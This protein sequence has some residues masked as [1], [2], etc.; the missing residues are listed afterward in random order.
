MHFRKF[1]P[2]KLQDCGIRRRDFF[3]SLNEEIDAYFTSMRDRTLSEAAKGRGENTILRFFWY[4]FKK[5]LTFFALMLLVSSCCFNPCKEECAP[6]VWR[7]S[8][9]CVLDYTPECP[10]DPSN[11][12][13]KCTNCKNRK[14]EEETFAERAV[15]PEYEPLIDEYYV[16]IGDVLEISVF[17]DED[18]LV[19]NVI[20]AP[21]GKIYY[22]NL[23]GFYAEGMTLDEIGEVVALGLSDLFLSP[24]V[25]VIPRIMSN[26]TF[27][28][29]GRVRH[30]GLFTLERTITLRQAVGIAGGILD[31]P[32]FVSGTTSQG[33][34]YISQ[35][36]N[37][38]QKV[39]SLKN[40]FI[41][42]GDKKLSIDFDNLIN[43]PDNTQDIVVKAGD[44]I[45]IAA[46]ESREVFVLG[47]AFAPSAV[48]YR[49]ELTLM[50]AL[51]AAGGWTT[52]SPY[53]AD[54][55]KVIL[56]RGCL[57][58]PVVA[59]INMHEILSGRARDV[60]LQPGDII[61]VKQKDFS[62]GRELVRTAI[63]TYIQSFVDRAAGHYVGEHWW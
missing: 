52:G 4:T 32:E 39:A 56:I 3:V 10:C 58:C 49:D 19:D 21:D 43:S 63:L 29:L 34:S 13:G 24:N 6:S 51:I 62:F 38:N 25:T 1:I 44:Y 45:Y 55:T 22:L 42:R 28:I 8:Y 60:Y 36:D 35:T 27:T 33:T 11:P 40:S 37:F 20:V 41:V 31:E 59:Q 61:Y 54:P 48:A 50:G 53:A 14:S 23:K 15:D 30:P 12:C 47:E 26:Q 57:N 18:T 9:D 16:A 2:K 17:G 7:S 46:D 5:Y